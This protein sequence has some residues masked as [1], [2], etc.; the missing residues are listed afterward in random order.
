MD[1]LSRTHWHVMPSYRTAWNDG[2]MG[3]HGYPGIHEVSK[4]YIMIVFTYTGIYLQYTIYLYIYTH[5]Y[6][7]EVEFY[8]DECR[9]IY[10]IYR[11]ILWGM[12]HLRP[13]ELSC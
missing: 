2:K 3:T 1:L 9:H 11:C 4:G 12:R 8:G 13:D 5:L 6:M 10:L 7:N